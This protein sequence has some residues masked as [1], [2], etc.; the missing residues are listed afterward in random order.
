[1]SS[2]RSAVLAAIGLAVSATGCGSGY[3]GSSTSYPPPP[4]CTAAT[5]TATTAVS[6]SGMS[7]VPSCITVAKAATITFT[8]DT[9]AT[10]HTVTTDPGQ[11]E[12]FDSGFIATGNSFA[13]TFAN[14]AE[15]VN[16]HCNV[17]PGMTATVI[18]Q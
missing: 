14:A 1:M 13:H 2:L 8:N 11:P 18:V 6:L 12:A 10:N 7:F 9:L 15:T 3:N 16:I 5:A 17:H 4:A